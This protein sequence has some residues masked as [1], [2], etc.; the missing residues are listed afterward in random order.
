MAPINPLAV[1]FLVAMF[2]GGLALV[3]YTIRAAHPT[4]PTIMQDAAVRVGCVL[5]VVPF[6]CFV[7]WISGVM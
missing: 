2:A 1:C 7:Y 5:I 6:I 3:V 4:F